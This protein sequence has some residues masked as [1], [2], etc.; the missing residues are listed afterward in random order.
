MIN[1]VDDILE[2][3]IDRVMILHFKPKQGAAK[4]LHLQGV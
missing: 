1:K 4:F 2:S 3:F